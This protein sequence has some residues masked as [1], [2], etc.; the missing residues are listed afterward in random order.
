MRGSW[1]TTLGGIIVLT[2]AAIS[3]YAHIAGSSDLAQVGFLLISGGTGGGL[4]AAR[5]NNKTS[6]EVRAKK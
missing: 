5:D 2:G 4:M 6:E 3:V 1:K